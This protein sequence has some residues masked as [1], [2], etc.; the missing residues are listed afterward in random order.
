[1][2]PATRYQHA[3]TNDRPDR[4]ATIPSSV[5]TRSVAMGTSKAA[6]VYKTDGKGSP[7]PHAG[8]AKAACPVCGDTGQRAAWSQ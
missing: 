1:M 3:A 6:S 5:R 7:R 4:K 8:P 2:Q